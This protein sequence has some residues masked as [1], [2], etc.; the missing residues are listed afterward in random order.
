MIKRVLIIILCAVLAL[1]SMGTFKLIRYKQKVKTITVQ[2]IDLASLDDGN[3]EGYYD[4]DLVKAK[5]RVTIK[6]ATIESI[7]LL[8][9]DHGKGK[10]AEAIISDVM[11][12]QKLDVDVITGATA[13]SKA[14]LKAIETALHKASSQEDK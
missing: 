7:D 6:G 2:K 5:V 14:I 3:Y 12:Q 13:S 9:H 4:L 1:L 11:A 10:R 8:E